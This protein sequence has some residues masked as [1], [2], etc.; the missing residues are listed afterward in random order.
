M[1]HQSERPKGTTASHEFMRSCLFSSPPPP[2]CFLDSLQLSPASLKIYRAVRGGISNCGRV[3]DTVGNAEVEVNVER[4]CHCCRHIHTSLKVPNCALSVHFHRTASS[5]CQTTATTKT[6]SSRQFSVPASPRPDK[7]D[8]AGRI[9]QSLRP[10][11]ERLAPLSTLSL[12]PLTQARAMSLPLR[13]PRVGGR[14]P[15]C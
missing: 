2:R 9:S 8:L 14:V 13:L 7:A 10:V 11:S 5:K 1:W 6:A 3:R 12:P 4:G 15:G